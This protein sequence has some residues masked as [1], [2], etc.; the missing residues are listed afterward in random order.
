MKFSLKTLG[1]VA[2]PV[3]LLG[4]QAPTSN[5]GSPEQPPAET[6]TRAIGEEAANE[7]VGLTL[8]AAQALAQ[9]N[10]VPLRIAQQDGE[11]F[12]LTAD[13]MHGRVNVVIENGTVVSADIESFSIQEFEN[14]E[15]IELEAGAAP[16][17]I[18]VGTID[19][20]S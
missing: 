17:I 10:N 5:Y 1:V 16:E 18:D 12:A 11:S 2:V 13:L 7:Y 8:E 19:L 9:T 6:S 14:I 20:D 4:C 15:Q 3:L